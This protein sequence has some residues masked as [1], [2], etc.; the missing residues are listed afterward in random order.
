M[1]VRI[2][3]HVSSKS[4]III[5]MI[6]LQFRQYSR[7]AE[8]FQQP[9]TMMTKGSTPINRRCV[10]PPMQ[11]LWPIIDCFPDRAHTSLHWFM[12]QDCVM[13]MCFP[14]SFS[15]ANNAAVDGMLSLISRWFLTAHSVLQGQLESVHRISCPLGDVFVQG[16]LKP[17][18]LTPVVVVDLFFLVRGSLE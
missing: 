6:S 9:C 14:N 2:E 3:E 17:P 1:L 15:K 18:N 8:D 7:K 13:G 12:N 4:P 5:G 11:K 16:A 10:V